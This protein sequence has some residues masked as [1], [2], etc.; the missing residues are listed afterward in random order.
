MTAKVLP[1]PRRKRAVSTPNLIQTLA[2]EVEWL[3]MAADKIRRG[4]RLERCE[5]ERLQDTIKRLDS[6]RAQLHG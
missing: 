1:F 3:A 2:T 5:R 4:Y 6:M